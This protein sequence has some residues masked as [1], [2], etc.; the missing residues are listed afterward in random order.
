MKEQKSEF[1]LIADRG[2]DFLRK[3][4]GYSLVVFLIFVAGLYGFLIMRVSSLGDI[5]PTQVSI[6][7][8]VQ[9]G[10]LPHLDDAIV[11]QLQS[12]QDNSVSVQTLFN[13]AR[14]NPFQE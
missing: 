2:V 3:A 11:R 4:R 1:K 9:A 13:E 14:S 7:K 12:L 6:D 5:E 8:Q 10:K